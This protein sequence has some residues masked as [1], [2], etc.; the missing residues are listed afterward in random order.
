MALYSMKEA[1]NKMLE[2]SRWKERYLAEKIK[3]DWEKL[4]GITVAKHTRDLIVKEQK[5]Y[6]YTDVAPLRNELSY[7]KTLL[8]EKINQHLEEN[9]IKEIILC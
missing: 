6:I 1:L 2:Q 5:L 3:L 8:I 4:M 7:N 9:F